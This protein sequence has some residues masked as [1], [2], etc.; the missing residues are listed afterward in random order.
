MKLHTKT[1]AALV[2]SAALGLFAGSV[3]ATPVTI[4]SHTFDGGAGSLDGTPV[5]TGTGSW[6]AANVVNANGVFATNPGS[7]TL[8]F[9]PSNGF[10]YTLD[11]RILNVTGD[12]NWVA[13]GFANGQSTVAANTDRFITENV[14]GTAWMLFRGNNGTNANVA[15]NGTGAIGAGNGGTASPSDWP[16]LNTNGGDIDMRILLDTTGGTGTWTA[17]W[18]AKLTTDIDYTTVRATTGVA[19]ATEANFTSVGFAFSAA[20]TDGTLQ[21]FSLT[22]VPEPGSLVLLGL[23]GLLI[24]ALRRRS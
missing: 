5:D 22:A 12:A 18:L 16:A 4:F 6:V 2:A 20:T 7:A 10:E 23:G 9:T 1:L 13:L 24:A 8:A 3:Q 11:A 14:V 21:S 17:T 15:Q 19:Q